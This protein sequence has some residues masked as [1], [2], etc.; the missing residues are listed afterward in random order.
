MSPPERKP[1]GQL[2]SGTGRKLIAQIYYAALTLFANVFGAVFWFVEHR[3]WRLADR[4]DNER[5]TQ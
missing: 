3:R 2:G 1:P 4:I 5:G